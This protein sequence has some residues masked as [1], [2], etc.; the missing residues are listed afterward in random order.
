MSV[1]RALG[2]DELVERADDEWAS[3]TAT[4]PVLTRF[5]MVRDLER[6]REDKGVPKEQVREVFLALGRLSQHEDTRENASAVLAR[7]VLPVCEALVRRRMAYSHATG[8][9]RDELEG[10]AAGA[11]WEAIANYPWDSPLMG[12]IPMAL[13]R[14]VTRAVDREFGWGDRGERVWRERYYL[15]HGSPGADGEAGCSEGRRLA[16]ELVDESYR[17]QPLQATEVYWWA[18]SEALVSQSEIELLVQLA[19]L[20]TEERAQTRSSG[21]ITSMALCKTVGERTGQSGLQVRRRAT[22]ALEQLRA[23]AA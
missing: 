18:I 6:W 17:S 4:E 10:L 14:D 19:V 21:G 15:D 2:I 5:A 16:D 7:L 23:H 9:S 12:S 20:A 8:V 3:W 1:W 13:Q 11:L 22:R